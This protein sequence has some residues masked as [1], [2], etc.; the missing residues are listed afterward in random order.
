MENREIKPE[1]PIPLY[2][3]LIT[4][5]L[6]EI[7]SGE[8]KP[9]EAIPTEQELMDKYGISRTTIRK[10][11]SDLIHA[12]I[13]ESRRPKGIFVKKENPEEISD[14]LLTSFTEE[15][16]NRGDDPT[17]KVEDFSIIIADEFLA[18]KL[19]IPIGAEVIFIMRLRLLNGIPRTI[20]YVYIPKNVTPNLRKEDFVTKGI[21]QSL[22]YIIQNLHG[23]E[24]SSALEEISAILL[25]EVEATLLL[26][27]TNSPNVVR[28]RQ[29][30]DPNGSVVLFERAILAYSYRTRL[31]RHKQEFPL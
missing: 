31:T 14:G 29:V 21:E 4:I 18:E 24:I 11:I 6:H 26:R 2:Y 30:F 5:L 23:V 22:Y 16:I 13:L 28:H 12:N 27:Q 9:N 8:I 25:S 19:E 1:S 7:Q 15:F 3:Q 17:S 10:A 20:S